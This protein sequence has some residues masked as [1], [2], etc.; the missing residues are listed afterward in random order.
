LSL[1]TPDGGFGSGQF[2]NA[3]DYE[4]TVG[5]TLLTAASAQDN[6]RMQGNLD[7]HGLDLDIDMVVDHQGYFEGMEGIK[8]YQ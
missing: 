6:S 8:A 3:A 1:Y 5:C 4:G 2:R 7:G